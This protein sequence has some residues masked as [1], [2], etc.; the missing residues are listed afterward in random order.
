MLLLTFTRRAALE[1]TR[2]AQRV[3]AAALAAQA[4]SHPRSCRTALRLP[5]S[6]HVSRDRQSPDPRARAAARARSGLQRARPR[7]CGRPDGRRA[8]AARL[9]EDRKALSAQ[10]HLPRDLLASRQHAAAAAP[11]ARDGLSLVPRVG[12]RSS[13]RCAARTSRP[14]SRS[15]CS[16]TTTCCSTGTLLMQRARRSPPE[17]ARASIT[18]WSTSTRTRTAAGRDPAAPQARRRGRHGRRRRCAGDLLV[19]CRDGREHPRVSRA[20]RR[21]RRAS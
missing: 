6:G 18:C 10:G 3:D 5:W 1:M 4:T 11:H 9:R 2:R 20:I 12:G 15:R 14:S 13:R 21:R 19:P 7:R 16:T 17:S 8:P